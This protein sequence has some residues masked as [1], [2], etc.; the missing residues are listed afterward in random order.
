[1]SAARNHETV[2]AI[3]EHIEAHGYPPSVRQLGK[4]LGLSSPASVHKRLKDAEAAG[5]I[6]RKGP[7]KLL[8]V[9]K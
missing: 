8:V 7:R 9:S 6:Q 1:M 3:T 5:L 4:L 2:K